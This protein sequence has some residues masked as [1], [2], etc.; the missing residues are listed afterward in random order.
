MEPG[1]IV[2]PRKSQNKIQS[3]ASPF[4]IAHYILLCLVVLI[5]IGLIAWVMIKRNNPEPE[6]NIAPAVIRV[7]NDDPCVQRVTETVLRMWAFNPRAVPQKYW[8]MA[9]NWLNQPITTRMYGLCQDVAFVCRVGQLR[10]DCDPCAV[11]SARD[12]A[13]GR[14]IADMIQENCNKGL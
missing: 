9:L 7:S 6:N 2:M 8:D 13:Q 10:K 14:H 11:P 4:N 1:G 5:C 12:Y 3:N